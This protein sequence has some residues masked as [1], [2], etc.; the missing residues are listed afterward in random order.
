MKTPFSIGTFFLG[1]EDQ[2]FVYRVLKAGFKILTVKN[3]IVTHYMYRIR[4]MESYLSVLRGYLIGSGALYLKHFRCLDFFAIV[5]L[6]SSWIERIFKITRF[7]L[8]GERLAIKK[9]RIGIV[10]LLYSW[11]MVTYWIILGIVKS[12]K[13]PVDRTY[14]LFISK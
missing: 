7:I 1:S 8:S 6:F 3:I 5:I 11:I 9:P 10:L 14:G 2:D 12:L 4:D 13:Y